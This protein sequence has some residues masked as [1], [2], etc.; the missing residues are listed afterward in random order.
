MIIF[1]TRGINRTVDSGQ[2]FCPRCSS[3]QP[4]TKKAVKR[5]FTLYFI[6][7]IPMGSAGEFIE[8]NGCAGTFAPE[9]LTYDP[10]MERKKTVDSIRR[11]AVSF[12]L[13]VNRCK[14]TELEALQDVVG[15]MVGEDVDSETVA[16]DVRQAQVAN[17]DVVSFVR[18][19]AGDLSDDGKWLVLT[20]MRRILEKV[21]PLM[22][23]EKDRL[24]DIGKAMGLRQKHINEFIETPLEN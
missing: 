2:F 7:L 15:D 19:Q 6:P 24:L 1:G 5:F 14:V 9:I 23:H 16:L 18:G 22:Q 13:D 17:V 12:L 21:S 3:D 8:C 4:F 11:M 20:T 10:E